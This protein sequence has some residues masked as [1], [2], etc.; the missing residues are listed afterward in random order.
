MY[1]YIYIYSFL[2][3]V[4]CSV[5]KKELLS[6]ISSFSK[7]RLTNNYKYQANYITKTKLIID[8]IVM[9]V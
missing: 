4:F 1:M 7:K 6:A 5:F 9:T 8:V 2:L 3:S